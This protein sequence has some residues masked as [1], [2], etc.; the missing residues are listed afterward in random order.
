MWAFSFEDGHQMF[1]F[2]T[3]FILYPVADD[4]YLLSS[5]NFRKPVKVV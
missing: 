5:S 1:C 3:L 4:A 2:M